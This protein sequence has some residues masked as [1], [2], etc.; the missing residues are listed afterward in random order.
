M[1]RA[2]RLGV[3]CCLAVVTFAHGGAQTARNPD[4]AKPGAADLR[5]ARAFDAA[6]KSPLALHVFL[7]QMPKGAD[8]HMHLSG[9]VYAETFLREAQEDHLCVNPI[10]REFV[11]NIGTTRT[12]PV[13]P[14][15]AQGTIPAADA[16][17]N[18]K[19][20]DELVDSFSMRSFVP[21]SG[22]SDHDQ[23]FATFS[24]FGGLNKDHAGEWLDEVATRAAA[25]N[26][27]Y[28]E[29]MQTPSF[30]TA[31]KLGAEMGWPETSATSAALPEGMDVTGTTPAELSQLRERLLAAGLRD[32]IAEDRTEFDAALAS[33]RRIEHCGQPDATAACAVKIRFLY[34]ILRANSPQQ[35][36]AQTLL[37]FEVASVDPDVVGLNFVQP[38]DA[39]LAMSEYTRQMRM[40]DYLHS[41]YPKVHLSLHAGE[42]APGL[43]P[44]A[45][46]RFHIREAIDLGHAERI[47]HGVDVMD[48][49]EPQALLREMA[50]RH[51]MV[52]INLTSND[53]ILGV[54]G[55]MHPLPS[56][57]AA[58]VPV[59]LS[60]DDEGVSRIDLTNE[61][62]RAALEF[63]LSY[64]QLKDM[65][66]TGIE[67][68]FL[69]G[70]SLWT[71]PDQHTAVIAACAGQRIG[72][73]DPKPACTAFLKSND[74][75]AE[76][77]EL[78]HRFAVFEST[79]P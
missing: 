33:R 6:K 71:R 42:L 50:S 38:E 63:N 59:A 76:E 66:R 13:Q 51:V 48:E 15:C 78:E 31:A 23:F 75:A 47:G 27:Q 25:Q 54:T 77:W 20:Y 62:T 68:S 65:A 17:K 11:K 16:F 35:V 4:A 56:Y 24:R 37:G 46:L 64:A 22:I 79:L 26:E 7:E 57:L 45:G 9:A 19:L 73:Q 60:T 30:S 1:L 14:V 5:A 2:L 49:D 44:P 8:L 58:H 28:L 18:Q 10:E 69:P 32:E 70:T 39:Y 43:V 52:E 3:V 41:V 55:N 40:L 72:A 29:I 34:Q 67:H 12:V 61:Y 53:V 21:S 74:K 36:F